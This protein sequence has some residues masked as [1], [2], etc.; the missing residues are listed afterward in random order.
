M[1]SFP[2]RPPGIDRGNADPL[3]YP[4]H[5]RCPPSEEGS[6]LKNATLLSSMVSSPPGLGITSRIVQIPCVVLSCALA[7]PTGEE[8]MCEKEHTRRKP[9]GRWVK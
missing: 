4:M 2:S 5:L 7:L 6:V 3:R 9:R 1:S 8:V